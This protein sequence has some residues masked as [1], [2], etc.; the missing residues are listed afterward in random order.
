[1]PHRS[2]LHEPRN[3]GPRLRRRST[4]LGGIRP[5][6]DTRRKIL[7]VDA[8]RQLAPPLTVV[9]GYFDLLGAGHARDLMAARGVDPLLAVVLAGSRTVLDQRARAELV[10]ALRMVDYVVIADD[11]DVDAFIGSLQPADLVRL[12]AA[13]ER[14]ARQLIE[15]VRRRQTR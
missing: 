6:V 13:D 15:H 3:G 5:R 7:T 11:G 2:P 1:M 8:A 10:A 12:E 4:T 9:T 14:R